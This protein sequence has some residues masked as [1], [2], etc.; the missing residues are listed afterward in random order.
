MKPNAELRIKSSKSQ[1]PQAST[2]P[3][4]P[5]QRDARR[6]PWPGKDI[7]RRD[8]LLLLRRAG[9][10]TLPTTSKHATFCPQCRLFSLTSLSLLLRLS[11]CI[12]VSPDPL[13]PYSPSRHKKPC[14]KTSCILS[15]FT[16]SSRQ[17][18]HSLMASSSLKALPDASTC[19][20]ALD[21]ATVLGC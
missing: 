13:R 6:E 10:R 1:E 2:G 11:S 15:S 9:V 19:I 21:R 4:D 14:A 16:G 5:T 18:L 20:E 8:F 12:R 7:R 3:C 17:A